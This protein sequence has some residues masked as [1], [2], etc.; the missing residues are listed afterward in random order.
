MNR[1]RS[2][3]CFASKYDAKT[4]IQLLMACF[5][6]LNP[7][8][9]TCATITNVPNFQFE[10]EEGNMVGVGASTEESSCAFVVEELV[11]FRRL[12]IPAS[13]FVDRLFW[14]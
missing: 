4:M 13:T 6:W 14:W 2:I 1:G 12:F 8:S 3:F 7:T 9:Q 11:L 5:D 10:K